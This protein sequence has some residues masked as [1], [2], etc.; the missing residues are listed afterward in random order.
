MCLKKFLIRIL[1]T[2]ILLRDYARLIIERYMFEYPNDFLDYELNKIKPQYKSIPIPD[3]EDQKYLE[4]NFEG[5]MFLLQWSMRFE[6]MGAYGDFGRYVF[7]RAVKNFDVDNYKVFNYALYYILNELGYDEKL[8]GE[9]DSYT[10]KFTLDRHCTI[11]I[12]RIGKKYQWIAMYNILARITDYYPM[13]NCA[14]MENELIPYDGPWEPYV[15][16][17]DPTLNEYN[18]V[19]DEAPYFQEVNDHIEEVVKMN[20]YT[21]NDIGFNEDEWIA[22]YTTFFEYQREDLLLTDS[23]K[24]QWIVLSK[25][26][27]TGIDT[28]ANRWLRECNGLYGY[29]VNDEQLAMLKEYAN[30]KINL[31]NNDIMEVSKTYTMYNRE[32][33]WSSGSKLLIENQW[34]KIEIRTGEK[35]QVSIT[36]EVPQL[37]EYDGFF[38]EYIEQENTDED[39]KSNVDFSESLKLPTVN[40]EFI[41]EEPITIDLGLALNTTQELLWEEEFDA[42]QEEA[43][44]ISHPCAEIINTLKL[45]QMKCDGYY[46]DENRELTAFDTDLTNQNAGLIIRKEAL[47][48]FLCI[49][50]LHLVWLINASKEIHDKSLNII[51]YKDWTGVLEYTNDSIQ[52]SYYI[53]KF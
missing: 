24:N 22:S 53:A 50:K 5:G 40:K 43:I 38:D 46:Y 35:K 19:C 42:S 32:Y 13:K 49:K 4:K 25:K 23:N 31:F 52:G 39:S 37:F 41:R 47:D 7:Q 9:Y 45:Y 3:I 33:P 10:D 6:G 11:K 36:V 44:L 14:S 26:V 30:K 1:Y 12:E 29:F 27:N 16:D 15:R 21:V 28:V 8:F 18:L 51:K 20:N 34:K 2:D 17:F 48:K